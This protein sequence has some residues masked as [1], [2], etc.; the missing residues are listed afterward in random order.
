MN[1]KISNLSFNAKY[2]VFGKQTP[3]E[4]QQVY[5]KDIDKKEYRAKVATQAQEYMQ[6][7]IIQEYLDWIPEDTFVCLHTGVLDGEKERSDK[8][9][10]FN[11]FLSFDAA[12]I[13]E[14]IFFSKNNLGAEDKLELTLND[15][16]VLDKKKINNWFDKIIEFYI[17]TK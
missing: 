14:Q 15:F 9:L 4:T 8:L 7:P 1:L 2:K 10:D 5:D 11:P 16:G 12:N 17:Q 13:N 3:Q 6:S